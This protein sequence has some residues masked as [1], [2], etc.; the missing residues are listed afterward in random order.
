MIKQCKWGIDAEM[1]RKEFGADTVL[2]E[3]EFDGD[4]WEGWTVYIEKAGKVD[5]NKLMHITSV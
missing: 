5:P 2:E 1:E 3:F 4:D